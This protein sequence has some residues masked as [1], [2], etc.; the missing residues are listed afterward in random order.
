MARPRAKPLAPTLRRLMALSGCD[1]D[2][3]AF[4]QMHGISVH[5]V[6]NWDGRGGVPLA[7]LAEFARQYGTTVDAL[8]AAG[9]EAPTDSTHDEENKVNEPP[10]RGSYTEPPVLA[11]LVDKAFSTRLGLAVDIVDAGLSA[12]GVDPS[13]VPKYE[14]AAAVMRL[15]PWPIPWKKR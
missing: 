6:R 13:E 10:P 2:I 9:E 15:L 14:M 8:S 7:R 5:T 11:Q 12:T 3:A 4:A 1:D